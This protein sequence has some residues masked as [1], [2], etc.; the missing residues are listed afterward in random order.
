[1]LLNRTL[2]DFLD[3]AAS[4]EPAPGGGA[5]AA[6]SGALACSMISMVCNLTVGKKKYSDVQDEIEKLLSRTE[7]LRKHFQDLI[8]QDSEAFSDVMGAM[9]MPKQSE[10]ESTLRKEAL[11]HA[12]Q[13]ATHVP[14]RTMEYSAESVKIA[15][16][17][18]QIGN[19]NV[20]SDIGVAAIMAEAALHSGWLSIAANLEAIDDQE[21][22]DRISDHA[23]QI[24]DDIDGVADETVEIVEDK[25][26]S[27]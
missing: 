16:R 11:Q 7:T 19:K 23:E 1:M 18:A 14:L 12:L 9:Q 26:Y 13:K 27:D 4:N 15:H 6:L 24:L 20:I 22:V 3:I 2:A 8:Q 10:N 5:V 17:V 25:I 21:F